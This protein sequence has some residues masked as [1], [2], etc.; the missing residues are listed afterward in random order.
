[1]SRRLT[2]GQAAA[3]LVAFVLGGIAAVAAELLLRD[4]G[5]T[6][7]SETLARLDATL[8][9]V[10]TGPL[11]VQAQVV[12]LPEGFEQQR[13]P[14]QATLILV[15]QGRVEIETSTGT[16]TYIAGT[17]FLARAGQPY[18]IRVVDTAELTSIDLSPSGA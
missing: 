2:P 18:T 6:P 12:R 9:T 17:S 11:A 5:T 10:E 8:T 15:Q 3:L 16:T 7:S 14:E 4:T 13:T 1:M